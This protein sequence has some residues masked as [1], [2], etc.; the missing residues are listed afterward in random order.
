MKKLMKSGLISLLL[1]A[2][3]ACSSQVSEKTAQEQKSESGKTRV[4]MATG[5]QAG[6]WFAVGAGMA[7]LVNKESSLLEMTAAVTNGGLENVRLV[8]GGKN[9]FSFASNDAA[10]YGFNGVEAFEK[11]GNQDIVG[12][13]TIMDS[14]RMGIFVLADS[15]I[16]SISDIK[17]KKVVVGPPSTSSLLMGLALLD[18]AGIDA[19]K[20]IEPL[21]LSYAEG[22][23]AL[24]DGNADVLFAMTGHPV[25]SVVEMS[26]SKDV[27]VIPVD[28]DI[29]KKMLE[30]TSFYTDSVI[31]AGTYDGQTEDIPSIG[32]P[33]G[34]IANKNVPEEVAYEFTKAVFENLED[35]K[36]YHAAARSASLELAAK[37]P[38]PMHPGAKKYFE[39]KG[40]KV[41]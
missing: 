36:S 1:L 10:Y 27:K 18:A 9:E 33:S 39:E 15:G 25:P 3:T 20:D 26:T 13:F 30:A 6:S 8:G 12:M 5:G 28:E 4:S 24:R 37:M 22:S 21:Y 32:L 41:D 31:K 38:I 29:R 11:E 35:V 23:E 34:I 7:N 19:K 2:F 17:G 16:K 40:I 14:S